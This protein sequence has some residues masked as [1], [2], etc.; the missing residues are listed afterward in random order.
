[1]KTVN[2]SLYQDYINGASNYNTILKY[3]NDTKNGVEFVNGFHGAIME[4]HMIYV[5][6]L[7]NILKHLKGIEKLRKAKL[8]MKQRGKELEL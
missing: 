6:L 2:K 7:N 3:L 1:M 5:F 8:R 4:A